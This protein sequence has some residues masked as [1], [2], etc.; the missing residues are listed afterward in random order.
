MSPHVNDAKFYAFTENDKGLLENI[1][2]DMFGGPSIVIT[3]KTVVIE[4]LIRDS[5]NVCKS[6][7]SFDASQFYSS[8]CVKKNLLVFA[9]VGT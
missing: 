2:D 7:V 4:T 5:A 9:R 1:R 3:R 6:F 8:H